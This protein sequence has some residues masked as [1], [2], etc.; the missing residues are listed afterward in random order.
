MSSLPHTRDPAAIPR[1]LRLVQNTTTPGV[2]SPEH[3]R[4]NGF[5]RVEGPRL[6]AFLRAIR[7]VDKDN[8]PTKHWKEY[9]SDQAAA[10]VLTSAVRIA[11]EPLF[12]AFNEPAR[13]SDDEIAVAVRQFTSFNETHVAQTVSSFRALCLAAGLQHS[14]AKAVSSDE[15]SPRRSRYDILREVAALSE[16][17]SAEFSTA[18]LALE[19]KLMRPAHVAAWNGYVALALMRMANDDFHALRR[20]RPKWDVT[21]IEDVAMRTPGRTLID[22]LVELRIVGADQEFAL[23]A[24]LQRRNDCA[25][26]T[27]FEPTIEQTADYLDDILDRG[28]A[29]AQQPIELAL[30]EFP[31]RDCDG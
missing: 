11:Y 31:T 29:L 19:Y 18:H 6:V 2:V 7:F 16:V 5:N 3:L 14:A 12:T 26:P 23:A 22:L 15:S 24:L 10:K 25:H 13:R 30:A 27:S 17:S 21:S 28:L 1:L 20:I 9:R 8:H 4:S